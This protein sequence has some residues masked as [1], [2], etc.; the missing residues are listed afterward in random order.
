MKGTS[1][2]VKTAGRQNTSQEKEEEIFLTGIL[3]SKPKLNEGKI[4]IILLK[5]KS[6][7]REE[8]LRCPT[9]GQYYKTFWY[10]YHL[11]KLLQFSH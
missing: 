6:A 2:A 8:F 9:G 11:E 5:L 3:D 7:K 10:H 4:R 1:A